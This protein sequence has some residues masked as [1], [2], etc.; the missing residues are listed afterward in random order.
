MPVGSA[1]GIVLLLYIARRFSS[2]CV[3]IYLIHLVL[4]AIVVIKAVRVS[5]L[6]V[7]VFSTLV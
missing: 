5:S 1:C 4:R 7:P 2:S 6:D 3:F